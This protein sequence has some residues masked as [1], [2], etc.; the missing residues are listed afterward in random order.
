MPKEKTHIYKANTDLKQKVGSGTISPELI[1]KAQK[2]IE[3]NDVDF[4]PLGLQFLNELDEALID[5]QKNLHADKF[6]SQKQ[7]LT[8]P[9]M[10]LKANAAMF[11][12]N[13]VGN[14]ASIML[15]FLETIDSLDTDALSIVRAHHDTLRGIIS[16]NMRGDGGDKGKICIQELEGACARYYK[17]KRKKQ[18]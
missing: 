12:F 14:L 18:D 1:E 3:D 5:V 9:V 7:D 10:E 4:S 2:G 8:Q 17:K 16:N 11:H 13:L 6:E 15:N